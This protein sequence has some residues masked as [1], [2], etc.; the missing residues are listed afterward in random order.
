MWWKTKKKCM[1][2]VEMY[3]EGKELDFDD[4]TSVLKIEP[5]EIFEKERIRVK[6]YAADSWAYA[7]DFRECYDIADMLYELKDIFEHKCDEINALA[8][9]YD[10]VVGINIL[11]TR[12]EFRYMPI[13]CVPGDIV[14]FLGKISC[15]LAFDLV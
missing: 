6:E 3:I 2:S 15:Q 14:E 9:K 10:A 7:I 12:D 5:T 1:V 11:M 13:V 8:K 4:I